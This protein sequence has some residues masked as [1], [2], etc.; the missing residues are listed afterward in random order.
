MFLLKDYI[1]RTFDAAGR[2]D[3]FRRIRETATKVRAVTADEYYESKTTCPLLENNSC[4]VYEA[5]PIPCRSWNSADASRCE[6][7]FRGEDLLATVPVDQ[8]QRQL[9][10]ATATG[11]LA[12]WNKLGY[13]EVSLDLT[14][15]LDIAIA[16]DRIAERWLEGENVFEGAEARS[17]S[18]M[19][20]A[21]KREV[22]RFT[23]LE[24][25]AKRNNR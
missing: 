11:M 22:E 15:A 16:D 6:E 3:I 4:Q 18:L 14:L 7:W 25:W 23:R 5:R 9:A 8:W 19:K 1:L 24:E 21:E 17:G 13:K 10:T 12:A 20:Q 2:E